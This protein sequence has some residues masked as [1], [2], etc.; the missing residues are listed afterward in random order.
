V[1]TLQELPE[2]NKRKEK[3]S[4]TSSKKLLTSIKEKGPLGK[5][6]LFTRKEKG[7]SKDQ[8]DCGQTSQQTSPDWF[9]GG[10]NAQENVWSEQAY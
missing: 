7:V 2:E 6:S 8:E 10:E 5:K 1:I 3:E 4:Y 9:E